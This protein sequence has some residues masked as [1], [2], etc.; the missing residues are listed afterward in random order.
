MLVSALVLAACDGGLGLFGAASRAVQV[1]QGSI[2]IA[3]PPGYCVDPSAT[4][5]TENGAFV[6]LGSC[7]SIANSARAP[8]PDIAGALTASVSV[9]GNGGVAAALDRLGVFFKSDPGR[10]ALARNGR[11]VSVTVLSAEISDEVF[12]LKV[13]DASPNSVSGLA[14]D[15]WR[16]LFDLRGRIVTLSVNAFWDKPMSDGVGRATLAEFVARVRAE[17]PALADSLVDPA[18]EPAADPV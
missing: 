18:L 13:R 4:R 12:I 17:N 11:A 6:L 9:E 15:Y 1:A 2:T 8:S 14:P 7:A 3:G 10:A 16:A 5:E